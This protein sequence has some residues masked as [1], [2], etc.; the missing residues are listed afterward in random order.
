MA[1]HLS[2]L[3]SCHEKLCVQLVINHIPVRTQQSLFGRPVYTYVQT[4]DN[5]RCTLYTFSYH[6]KCGSSVQTLHSTAALICEFVRCVRKTNT[7]THALRTQNTFISKYLVQG[8]QV[9]NAIIDAMLSSLS[10][11][12]PNK[13]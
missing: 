1:A 8:Q 4:I 7:F 5:F 6:D 11:V 10:F 2:S 3:Y 12:R 13:E 9:A